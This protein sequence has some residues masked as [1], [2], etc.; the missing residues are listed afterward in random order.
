MITALFELAVFAAISVLAAFIAHF[1][2]RRYYTASIIAAIGA[3]IASNFIH[4]RYMAGLDYRWPPAIIVGI[5]LALLTALIIGLPISPNRIIHAKRWVLAT[6]GG[7]VIGIALPIPIW[8]AQFKEVD[9]YYLQAQC[10]GGHDIY[11]EFWKGQYYET[12]PG[13]KDRSPKGTLRRSG[14]IWELLMGNEVVSTITPIGDDQIEIELS[15]TKQ[16]YQANRV[17]NPWRIWLPWILPE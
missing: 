1:S 6:I 9:G 16:K 5:M 2:L 15:D 12:C 7:F 8:N 14:N 11:A 10:M 17:R 4:Y 3:N 13:H